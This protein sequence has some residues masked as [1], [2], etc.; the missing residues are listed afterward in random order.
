MPIIDTPI[1]TN[2][3]ARPYEGSSCSGFGNGSP[4]ACAPHASQP[5]LKSP[6]N[7]K[8]QQGQIVTWSYLERDKKGILSN[9]IRVF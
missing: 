1:I 3:K 5:S 2:T 8:P 6:A 4:T 9:G 7:L